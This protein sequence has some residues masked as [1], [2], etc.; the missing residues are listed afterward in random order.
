MT[1]RKTTTKTTTKTKSRSFAALRMTTQR[2]EQRARA[3]QGNATTTTD[4][5]LE[6]REVAGGFRLATNNDNG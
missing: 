4:R 6:I 2:R 3:T 5:G 1:T